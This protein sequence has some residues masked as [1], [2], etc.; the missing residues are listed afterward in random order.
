MTK[1]AVIVFSL[2]GLMAALAPP[3]RQVEIHFGKSLEIGRSEFLFGSIASICEGSEGSFY[4]LDDKEFKVFRFSPEGRLIQKFGGKGQGPGDFQS[5]NLIVFTTQAEIAVLENFYVSFFKTAG[6]FIRRLN[7]SDR[8]GLSYIGP[9]R[10]L[11]W[12]WLPAGR[13]QMMVDGQNTIKAT[14]HTQPMDT[15]STT[16]IDETGQAVGF[17]YTSNVYVP[18]LLSGYGGGVSLSGISS[19]YNLT[20]LDENGRAIGS[21]Q[22]DVMP[23][24]ISGRERAY[25][26]REFREFV[27]TRGWPGR[28]VREFINKIPDFKTII[29]AVRIS[30]QHVFVFRVAQDITREDIAIPVD[31][32]SSRG[33]FFGSTT[34]IQVPL[35]ISGKSMYF[36]ETDNSGNEYLRRSEYSLSLK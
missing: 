18:E 23:G 30:P 9:D 32:F 34:L 14:F 27:A 2:L 31:V 17:N 25:L 1:S 7:L 16:L 35:F 13:N 8:L 15:F 36:V 24:K 12:D 10:F 26:E 33:E 29:S 21:V 11:C 4:V 22:R 5:P 19:L 28:I 6:I 20:L 3:E